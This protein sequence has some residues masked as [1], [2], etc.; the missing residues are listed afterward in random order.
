MFDALKVIFLNELSVD[1]TGYRSVSGGSINAAY[2]AFNEDKKWFIKLNSEEKYPDMFEKEHD[3][4]TTLRQTLFNVPKALAH[5]THENFTYLI[6]DFIES[7]SKDEMNW[8]LFGKSLAKMHLISKSKFGLNYSNY[9]GSLVQQNNYHSTWEDFYINERL[10]VLAELGL[11]KN[12]LTS[13]VVKRI[14]RLC[15]R[16]SEIVPTEHPGLVHGDLWQG[17]IMCNNNYAPVLIDPAVYYGHREMDIGM[18]HLFGSVSKVALENYQNIYPL[19]KGWL[20]RMD[21]FQLY[22]LLVHLI[23]FGSSYFNEVDSIVKKYD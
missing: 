16:L 11:N 23:L 12:L 21:V 22:P 15:I 1:L 10:L 13:K 9:I 8:E 20:D 18:L 7:S 6:L 2:C 14:E 5:G 19:E 3:G 4:L 17:N